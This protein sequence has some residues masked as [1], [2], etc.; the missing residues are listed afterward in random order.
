M[1]L[2]DFE[3]MRSRATLDDHSN[4][5]THSSWH[6]RLLSPGSTSTEKKTR[7][8]PGSV[9]RLSS[10]IAK[11]AS[12]KDDPEKAPHRKSSTRTKNIF[13][14]DSPAC[15]QLAGVE[16]WAREYKQR[17]MKEEQKKEAIRKEWLAVRFKRF[18]LAFFAGIALIGPMVLMTLVSS[19]KCSLATT[20]LATLLFALIV[21][22]YTQVAERDIIIVVA[23]YAAV[24]VVFVGTQQS[25]NQA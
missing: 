21:A 7:D 11:A 6:D 20:S 9:R 3:E 2:K 10:A 23:G 18:S 16:D 14:A 25:L 8:A 17:E 13:G 22:Y 24:L 1:A 5:L 15:R 19:L 12:S 4:P